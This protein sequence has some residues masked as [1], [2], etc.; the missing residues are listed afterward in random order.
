MPR[1]PPPPL[2]SVK[3]KMAYASAEEMLADSSLLE[4]LT[5]WARHARVENMGVERLFALIRKSVGGS[6]AP[7]LDR[8]CPAGFMAQL[9]ATH[10][11]CGGSDPSIVTRDHLRDVPTRANE[12]RC[13]R[14][15]P[16]CRANILYFADRVRERRAQ[17][18]RFTRD[19]HRAERRRLLRE[20]DELDDVVKEEYKA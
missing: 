16:N 17:G 7:V 14:A 3:V 12:K 4:G 6:K 18:V 1:P 11:A 9:R 20:F 15:R 2:P 19:E 8:L 5:V 13:K 10:S